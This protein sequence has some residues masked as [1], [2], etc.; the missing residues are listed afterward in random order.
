MVEGGFEGVR[1]AEHAEVGGVGAVYGGFAVLEEESVAGLE[2]EVFVAG[3][4]ELVVGLA[5]GVGFLAVE[6]R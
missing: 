6:V 3:G 5:E 1:V 4:G 2:V